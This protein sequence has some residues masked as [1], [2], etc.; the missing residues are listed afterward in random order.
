MIFK[1]SFFASTKIPIFF[2]SVIKNIL[3]RQC[4][5]INTIIFFA[6]NFIAAL[7]LFL[8]IIFT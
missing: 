7:I 1:Y 8:I 4:E 5:L 6:M 3:N 2:N